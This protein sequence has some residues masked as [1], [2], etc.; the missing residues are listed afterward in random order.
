MQRGAVAS[1]ATSAPTTSGAP[2]QIKYPAAQPALP[3]GLAGAT[4]SAIFGANQSPLEV[5]MLKRRIMGPSW[6]SIR[7]PQ[8]VALAAQVSW[9]ALEVEVPGH[10]HVSAASD[11]RYDMDLSLPTELQQ[12][13]R[14]GAPGQCQ[15]AF[16]RP[17][18]P[19]PPRPVT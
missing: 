12:S 19:A 1:T 5:L 7:Q 9:C 3:P 10:K 4:F 6:L 17:A 11:S 15:G 2:V 8:R 13:P 16:R 18:C 14:A